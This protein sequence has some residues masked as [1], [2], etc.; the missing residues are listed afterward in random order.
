MIAAMVLKRLAGPGLAKALA[1]EDA[2][3]GAAAELN[4]AEARRDEIEH[5]YD[6]GQIRQDAFLRMHGPAVERVDKARARLRAQA[7]QSVLWS[8]PK[9]KAKL[10]AWWNDPDRT[11]DEQ[12]AVIQAVVERVVVGPA[13]KPSRTF[14]EDRIRPPFGPVW[15]DRAQP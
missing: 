13:V 3:P 14:N 11:I 15:R 6:S 4:A 10:E 1:A 7:S 2:D 5:L 12:R 9:T 8:L